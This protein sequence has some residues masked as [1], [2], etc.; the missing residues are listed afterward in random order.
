MVKS[1]RNL[2]FL[3][4]AILAL[5][6]SLGAKAIY[7]WLT[8]IKEK[9][10]DGT[11]SELILNYDLWFDQN[12]NGLI[13]AGE[14]AINFYIG[15]DEEE[16]DLQVLEVS[17]GNKDA[18]NYIGNLRL[19]VN[20]ETNSEYYIRAKF[21]SEW[22]VKKT[23]LNTMIVRQ[24]TLALAEDYLMPYTLADNWYYDTTSAYTYYQNKITTNS[25]VDV[26][27]SPM[28]KT[29]EYTD[30]TTLTQVTIYSMYL[31]VEIEYVQANRMSAIWGIDTI[32][33]AS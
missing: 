2:I 12:N 29:I 7:A 15:D 18:I 6:L 5:V 26:V 32:P 21:N 13:D 1:K 9:S 10:F 25:E 28:I 4:I 27:A 3:L 20:V 8:D 11:T 31:D 22:F 14:E 30:S 16:L 17:V 24:T 33:Q 23:S 19:H